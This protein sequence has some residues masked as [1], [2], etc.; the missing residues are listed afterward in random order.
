M[1][2]LALLWALALI[3]VTLVSL[4]GIAAGSAEAADSGGRTLS[5]RKAASLGVQK[6][7]PAL[8][9]FLAAAVVTWIVGSIFSWINEHALPAAS[10]LTF[11]LSKPVSHVLIMRV[12]VVFEVVAGLGMAGFLLTLLLVLLQAGHR[13]VWHHIGHAFRSCCLGACLVTS[14]VSVGLFGGIANLVADW[15]PDISAGF[16]DYAQLVLRMG[17]ALLL[18]VLGWVFWNLALAKLVVLSRE[19]PAA[20]PPERENVATA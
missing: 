9:M 19:T 14:L 11:H 7:V 10:F 18:L 3:A 20:P 12:F 15:H 5:L 8:L 1:L 4:A 13:E 2:I 6:I 17:F 16:A